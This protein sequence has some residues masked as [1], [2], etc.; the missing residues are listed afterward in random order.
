MNQKKLGETLEG[1]VEDCVNKVGVDLNTASAPLLQYISGVGKRNSQ[2]YSRIPRTKR[3][4]YK[5]Q[6]VAES[7]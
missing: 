4:F 3:A 7:R 6:S 5:S 1:V 2:K